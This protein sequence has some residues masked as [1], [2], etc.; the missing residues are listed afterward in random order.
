ME[1][2][3]KKMEDSRAEQAAGG[4]GVYDGNPLM[5]ML[6][7]YYQIAMEETNPALKADAARS[8]NQTLDQLMS[9]GVNCAGY[10]HIP[11]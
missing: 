8:Y 9:Q 10:R 5:G 11:T 3:L 4:N 1:N 7:L 2:T 6:D